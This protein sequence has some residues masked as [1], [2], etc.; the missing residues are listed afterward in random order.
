[1]RFIPDIAARPL[2]TSPRLTYTIISSALTGHARRVINCPLLRPTFLT[3]IN[4]PR[5][6][7]KGGTYQKTILLYPLCGCKH[8]GCP[9]PRHS[10]RTSSRDP[11]LLIALSVIIAADVLLSLLSPP[12]MCAL[13]PPV[14]T[15]SSL[16]RVPMDVAQKFGIAH[17][18]RNTIL[19]KI[20]HPV[21]LDG[22]A[23]PHDEALLVR[24]FAR[25]Q[26]PQQ[27][28]HLLG[29]RA[30]VIHV[31]QQR[32]RHAHRP[33]EVL[34]EFGGDGTADPGDED[35]AI[36]Q[37]VHAPRVQHLRRQRH[38][39]GHDDRSVGARLAAVVR[40]GVQRVQRRVQE[41]QRGGQ[42]HGHHGVGHRCA[43]VQRHVLGS[44]THGLA[45]HH[46]EG[47]EAD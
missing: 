25:A 1:M 37:E 3:L 41:A 17:G 10:L 19:H 42:A 46:G 13:L 14:C 6:C 33:E 35:A 18:A 47:V 4:G 36:V 43:V 2:F 27:L 22:V 30:V 15:K 40:Q 12:T 11:F 38:R 21:R 20:R 44:A 23:L 16:G 28:L 24:I 26:H 39:G 29:Q 31:Q 7:E 8:T 5:A 32:V 45:L 34:Q 9:C